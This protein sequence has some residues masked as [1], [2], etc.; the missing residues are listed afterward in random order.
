[1]NTKILKI[2]LAEAVAAGLVAIT[3]VSPRAYASYASWS[4]PGATVYINPANGDGLSDSAVISALQ[5]AMDDWNTQGGSPFR[6]NYGGQVRDTT[7]GYDGRNVVLF[8]NENNGGT[9]AYTYSWWDASNHLLDSDMIIYDPGYTFY[10]FDGT[11]DSSSGYGVY[12]WRRMKG[13]P[14]SVIATSTDEPDEQ[15]LHR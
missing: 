13:R 4:S 1:M 3:T 12:V 8:R 7:T 5:A 6:F 14:V 9:I 11:C 15:G 10:A 2:A